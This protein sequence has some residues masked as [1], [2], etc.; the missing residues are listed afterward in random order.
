MDKTELMKI[1]PHRDAMLLIDE[2]QVVDGEARAKK[3]IKP[4]EWYLQG[5]FP[6]HPVVP[7]VILCE[8]L[9]QSTCVLLAPDKDGRTTTLLTGLNNVRFRRPVRPGD[10]LETRCAI[11]K[12]KPPFYWAQGSGFVDGALC[13][14]AE[15][16]FAVN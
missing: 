1:L 15:F 7:G 16:S 13:V 3:T 10:V 6:D 8:I 14:T 2:A 5:H 12:Q 11:V 9:A 4:D